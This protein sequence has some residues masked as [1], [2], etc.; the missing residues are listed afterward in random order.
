MARPAPRN[1]TGLA[2]VLRRGG[3][4]SGAGDYCWVSQKGQAGITFRA[5]VA[6]TSSCSLTDTSCEPRV[7]IGLV[8]A[9]VRLSTCSPE[10]AWRASAISATVTAPNRRPPS[11]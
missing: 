4:A 1:G 8:T 2:A 7:L 10:V 11:P 3:A 5:T 9:I 6:D